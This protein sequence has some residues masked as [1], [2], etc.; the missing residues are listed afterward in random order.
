MVISKAVR[1]KRRFEGVPQVEAVRAEMRSAVDNLRWHVDASNADI[2]RQES[3][4]EALLP[5]LIKARLKRL[6]ALT[7]FEDSLDLG[8]G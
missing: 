2:A 8:L 4:V 5:E 6:S 3:E 1:L 7:A